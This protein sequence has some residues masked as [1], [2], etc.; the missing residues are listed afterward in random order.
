MLPER[1]KCSTASSL[2]DTCSYLQL[3]SIPKRLFLELEEAER[4]YAAE[5][6]FFLDLAVTDGNAIDQQVRPL[7]CHVQTLAHG[8]AAL[9]G[10]AYVAQTA[11]WCRSIFAHQ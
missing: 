5:G 2:M 7:L 9:S 11:S 3:F 4:S 1:E 10:L 8:T 6:L